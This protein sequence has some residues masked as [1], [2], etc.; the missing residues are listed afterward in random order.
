MLKCKFEVD[1][2]RRSQF[3]FIERFVAKHQEISIDQIL[4]ILKNR[5]Q[6]FY[7]YRIILLD[8]N[9]VGDVFES[10]LC[11]NWKSSMAATVSLLD[12]R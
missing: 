7:A 6:T 12:F 9:R 5:S 10:A 11:Y 4:D 2:G 8:T 1:K 3:L